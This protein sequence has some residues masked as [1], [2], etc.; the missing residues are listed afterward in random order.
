MKIALLGGTGALGRGLAYRLSP[1]FEVLIG[2][3]ELSKAEGAAERY[4][5][6]LEALGVQSRIS[7]LEN[8]D[9][10]A[11]SEVSVLTIPYP[12]TLKILR[13]VGEALKGRT[14]ASPVVPMVKEGGFF[15]YLPPAA[16]S[17]ALEIRRAL[18]QDS[19]LVAAFHNLPAPRL[20][21][22]ERE[23]QADVILCSDDEGGKEV[24]RGIVE[25]IPGLRP[26]DGGPLAVSA[27]VES[28]T[29]LLLN[30]A[31]RNRF[32]SPTVRFF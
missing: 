8:R 22:L 1:H 15:R 10:A 26:L 30:I 29:P 4:R 5:K 9:A 14:V 28:I 18:P 21:D 19:Q 6:G 31:E 24:L 23:L 7:G 20:A 16:G 17:A 2:S 13:E 11:R 32:P 12:H 27:Q 3:R 25:E